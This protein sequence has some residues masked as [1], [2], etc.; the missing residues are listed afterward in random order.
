MWRSISCVSPGLEWASQRRGVTPLVMLVKRSGHRLAKSAKM[1]LTSRSECSADTPL[2]L[3]LPTIDRCAMRTRRSPDSSISD[4]RRRNWPSPGRCAAAR[5][6][7]SWLMC[8]MI[9][10]C[11]GSTC[12]ISATDQVSSASGISVWL[13]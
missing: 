11:R 2:T 7:K 3:W 9:S 8:R 4:S 13:V 1:V 5:S 6:R 10:R 12:C